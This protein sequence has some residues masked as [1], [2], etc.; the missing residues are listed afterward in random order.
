ME[1]EMV[2]VMGV[3]GREEKVVKEVRVVTLEEVVEGVQKGTPLQLKCSLDRT[4]A[5]YYIFH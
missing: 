4:C 1:T 5:L 3:E 2:M